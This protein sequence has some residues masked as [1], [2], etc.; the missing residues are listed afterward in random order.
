MGADI[1]S[2][3]D[4]L[5]R[6]NIS[7]YPVSILHLCLMIRPT[8]YLDTSAIN[9]L[10]ADDAP[11]KQEITFDFFENYV[12][13]GIYRTYWSDFVVDEI[14]QTSDETKKSRLLHVFEDY[15]IDRLEIQ[16]PEEVDALAE[17]YLL[18]GVMPP[19]KLYDALHVACCVVEKIDY[20]VSWN[21]KHL[22]NVN[23]ERKVLALNYQL[24]F[25]HPLRI[26]TPTDLI[27]V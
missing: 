11:E 20:L 18:H 3:T 2:L 21:Y 26:L 27:Y 25:L 8:V 4:V 16:L 9:F 7:R 22:A 19:K 17:Q 13:T 10:F 24:G 14:N 12:K 5:E 15:Y 6:A 1:F 23:R